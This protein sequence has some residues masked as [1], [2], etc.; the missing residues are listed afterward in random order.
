MV[1]RDRVSLATTLL[2]ALGTLAL[3]MNMAGSP[4]PNVR[5]DATIALA[6][7]AILI[8]ALLGIFLHAWI[9]AR[10]TPAA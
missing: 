8:V 9:K 5:K 2:S 6:L 4:H 7:S 3:S 1:M 10:R